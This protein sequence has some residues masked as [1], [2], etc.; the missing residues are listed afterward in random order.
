MLA[1]NHF[2]KANAYLAQIRSAAFSVAQAVEDVRRELRD[3]GYDP[4]GALQEVEQIGQR[5]RTVTDAM[6]AD[7]DALRRPAQER[8]RLNRKA[9][10]TAAALARSR[11]RAGK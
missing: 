10:T 4:A 2:G 3:T 11:G 1:R 9:E 7:I 8:T 6:E 5:L